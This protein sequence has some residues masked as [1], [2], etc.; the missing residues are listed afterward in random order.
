MRR[1]YD[2]QAGRYDRGIAFFERVLF[3]GG[4][5]WVCAQ[6]RGDVLEIAVGTGRNLP[7]YPP[8]VRL[9]GID[10]SPQMLAIARARAAELGRPVELAEGDAQAL[11][12]A[13]RS[14]DTVVSTLS[15]CSIPGHGQAVAEINR[16]LRPGGM[17]VALEHVR[18]PAML[19]RGGQRLLEPLATRFGGDHL[20]R[21]PVHRLR[22]EGLEIE[23][24]ERSKWG[25]VERVRARKPDQARG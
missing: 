17:F 8:G 2:R 10:I 12:F 6:A 19:V 24:L 14:F 21:E 22:T 5:E 25:I 3:K 1:I 16:V 15:L 4:R 20:L 18:S 23:A 13:D 9:T 11:D 7:L